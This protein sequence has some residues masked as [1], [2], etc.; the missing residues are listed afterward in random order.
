MSPLNH[1]QLLLPTTNVEEADFGN[2]SRDETTLGNH[3]ISLAGV[4]KTICL[5][6]GT[7]WF[8]TVFFSPSKPMS[9]ETGKFPGPSPGPPVF[10]I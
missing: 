7:C 1:F 5:E 4:L 6:P 8:G 3:Q 9:R 10:F 2:L